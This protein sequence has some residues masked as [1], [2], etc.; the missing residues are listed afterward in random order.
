MSGVAMGILI[1]RERCSPDEAFAM[2]ARASQRRN[3]KLR[4]VAQEL[5]DANVRRCRSTGGG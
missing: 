3:R 2:L 5:I 4:Q 1:A